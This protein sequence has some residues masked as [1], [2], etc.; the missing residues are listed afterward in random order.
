MSRPYKGTWEESRAR[1]DKIVELYRAGLN[2]EQIG[3]Q[4]HLTKSTVYYHLRIARQ[5]RRGRSFTGGKLGK[6]PHR[7]IEATISLYAEGLTTREVAVE[8]GLTHST[9]R[10]RLL[11]AGIQLRPAAPRRK[12]DAAA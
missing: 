6:T 12:N 1:R 9:V 5:R 7:D 3:R 4:V 11:N 8:L 2:A 10:Y